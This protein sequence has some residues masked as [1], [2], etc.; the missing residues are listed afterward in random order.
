MLR[1]ISITV[2]IENTRNLTGSP[3]TLPWRIAASLLAKRAKSP[4]LNSKAAN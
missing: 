2:M 4:E 1:D 3:R